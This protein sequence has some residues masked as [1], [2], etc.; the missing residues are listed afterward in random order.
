MPGSSKPGVPRGNLELLI[1]AIA[2]AS[3][4]NTS[5]G[6]RV[7]LRHNLRGVAAPDC[8]CEEGT[9]AASL[10]MGGAMLADA[11][12]AAE[13]GLG[14]K[15]PPPWAA[16][17][18]GSWGPQPLVAPLPPE[19]WDVSVASGFAALEH[20]SKDQK[21]WVKSGKKKG[22]IY[23]ECV[24]YHRASLSGPTSCLEPPC[25]CS[26]HV[27]TIATRAIKS[28]HSHCISNRRRCRSCN[29]RRCRGLL[30]TALAIVSSVAFTVATSSVIASAAFFTTVASLAVVANLPPPNPPGTVDVVAFGIGCGAAAVFGACCP[31]SGSPSIK[32]LSLRI[33]LLFLSGGAVSSDDISVSPDSDQD[34]ALEADPNGT[35]FSFPLPGPR[36][37]SSLLQLSTTSFPGMH[38]PRD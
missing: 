22:K 12:P 6:G 24:A 3:R 38:T 10:V 17:T 4:G 5:S 32:D 25:V 8:I 11:T 31:G 9:Y 16:S 14:A 23:N 36:A 20:T 19:P 30:S 34:L 7:H 2:V 21:T 35:A 18:T 28:C 37:A 15:S 27:R 29:H 13:S 33:N 1:I 26:H